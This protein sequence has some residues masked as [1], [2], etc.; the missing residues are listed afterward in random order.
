[1]TA[2]LLFVN[3]ETKSKITDRD[4]LWWRKGG[5]ESILGSEKKKLRGIFGIYKFSNYLIVTK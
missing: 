2:T 4:P 3:E 5:R 1:M